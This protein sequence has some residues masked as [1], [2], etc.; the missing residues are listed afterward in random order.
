VGADVFVMVDGVY[1]DWGTAQARRFERTTPAEVRELDF[2]AG[3]MG[4][5]VDAAIRF[6]RPYR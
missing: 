1:R 6:R 2:A 4:S 5:K 3:S